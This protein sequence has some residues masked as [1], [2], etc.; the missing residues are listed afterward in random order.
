MEGLRQYVISITTAAMICG[1]IISLLTKSKSLP[2]IKVLCGLFLTLSVLKPIAN[3]NLD[4][5][6][7]QWDLDHLTQGKSVIS[8]GEEIANESLAQII[9]AETEAYILDKAE[10][11]GA[12]LQVKVFLKEGTPPVPDSAIIRGTISPYVKQNLMDMM[13]SDL[14]IAKEKQRWVG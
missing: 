9:T 8:T 5:V 6:I 4:Q 10:E 7:S 1:M 13:E 12:A 11:L 3:I 2:V 14:G